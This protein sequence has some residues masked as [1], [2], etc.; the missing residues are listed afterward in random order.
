ML[1]A[2]VVAKLSAAFALHCCA[3]V[4]LSS[5][6]DTKNHFHHDPPIVDLGFGVLPRAPPGYGDFLPFGFAFAALAFAG[7]RERDH[8]VLLASALMAARS[9]SVAVTAFPPS[10]P[11]CETDRLAPLHG[12]CRDK[13]FSGHVAYMTLA[14]LFLHRRRPSAGPALA[15]LLALEAAYLVAAHEHYTVDVLLA[16]L[17]AFLLYRAHPQRAG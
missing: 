14:A 3:L 12:G 9:V 11:A 10:D 5:L 8:F 13:V 15:V 6:A 7:R 2:R 17:I 16:A 1:S 4:Y